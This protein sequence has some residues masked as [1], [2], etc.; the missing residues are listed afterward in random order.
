MLYD[1]LDS[2]FT[3]KVATGKYSKWSTTTPSPAVTQKEKRQRDSSGDESWLKGGYVGDD[4][5]SEGSIDEIPV[6]IAA[7]AAS[8]PEKE[9]KQVPGRS[10][11]AKH[12]SDIT[13]FL[14][15]I[16]EN[17]ERIV[18]HNMADS[19]LEQALKI[20]SAKYNDINVMDRIKFKMVLSALPATSE[21]FLQMDE[22]EREAFIRQTIA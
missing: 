8:V 10:V 9:A 21:M 5:D 1:D 6:R 7:R 4:I 12:G 18:K 11:R 2:I 15:K 17:Q 19:K 14:G 22:E 16:V 20:F 13:S 3:G